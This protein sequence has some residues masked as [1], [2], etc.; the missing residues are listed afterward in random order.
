MSAILARKD[1]LAFFLQLACERMRLVTTTAAAAAT[2]NASGVA[3]DL[4][5]AQDAGSAAEAAAAAAASGAAAA[6]VGAGGGGAGNSAVADLA[7][8]KAFVV[9]L[10]PHLH[11]WPGDDDEN[12]DD[13]AQGEGE[14]GDAPQP[15]QSQSAVSHKK[16]LKRVDTKVLVQCLCAALELLLADSAHQ[17]QQQQ[18]QLVED[19]PGQLRAQRVAAAAAAAPPGARSCLTDFFTQFY[20]RIVM[21]TPPAGP[22][23]V[24]VCACVWVRVC[25]SSRRR[26]VGLGWS[27]ASGETV[28]GGDMLEAPVGCQAVGVVWGQGRGT[29]DEGGGRCSGCIGGRSDGGWGASR[30]C[31]GVPSAAHPPCTSP[32]S[33]LCT[34]PSPRSDACAERGRDGSRLRLQPRG[35]VDPQVPIRGTQGVSDHHLRFVCLPI[36]HQLVALLFIAC[37]RATCS[38]VDKLGRIT[39]LHAHDSGMPLL[40]LPH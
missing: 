26:R 38:V 3:A 5:A 29:G 6:A 25:G 37:F 11:A 14:D 20:S 33:L 24:R 7:A 39:T 12:D 36:A 2:T 40:L 23:K 19:S 1:V 15:S 21:P 10:A 28:R 32:L 34:A 13:D 30:L 9:H 4:Q 35:P 22:P 8:L 16:K 31:R 27:A 18:Q 17:Q